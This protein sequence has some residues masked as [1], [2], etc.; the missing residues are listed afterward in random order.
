M[1]ASDKSKRL[2]ARLIKSFDRYTIK[3][4]DAGFVLLYKNN[5]RIQPKN[6]VIRFNVRKSTSL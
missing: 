2:P 4:G 1:T 3:T 5:K 6:T